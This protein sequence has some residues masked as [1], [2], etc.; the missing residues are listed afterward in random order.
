MESTRIRPRSR[1][2]HIVCGLLTVSFLTM[3]CATVT[4]SKKPGWSDGATSG[5]TVDFNKKVAKTENHT[6]LYLWHWNIGLKKDTGIVISQTST[7]K[8]GDWMGHGP[9]LKATAYEIF[10]DGSQKKKWSLEDKV[11]EGEI[12]DLILLYH[13]I[14]R[15]C[16]SASDNHRFYNIETGELV[17]ECED[18]MLELSTDSLTPRYIGYKSVNAGRLNPWEEDM[19]YIG[20]LTYSTDENILQRIVLR[21]FHEDYEETFGFGQ[22]DISFV[23]NGRE[24]KWARVG[25]KDGKTFS[26]LIRM[27]FTSGYVVDIPIVND[28]LLIEPG[29]YRE[30]EMIKV[31]PAEKPTAN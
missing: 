24:M 2:I 3:S 28:E 12:D 29:R 7:W 6:F 25:S 21:S 26:S 22:A 9:A 23:E 10:P 13:T 17:M 4:A 5:I 18:R 19:K 1:I 30:F 20:T 8:L 15:G 31:W 16:C 11:D 14:R 27:R